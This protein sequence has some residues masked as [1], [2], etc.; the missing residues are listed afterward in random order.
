MSTRPATRGDVAKGWVRY[1][2][3][4]AFPILLLLPSVAIA[5][6]PAPTPP[7]VVRVCA[8]C[9]PAL[10]GGGWQDISDADPRSERAWRSLLFRMQ[11]DYGAEIDPDE[12][13]DLVE[14]LER[15]TR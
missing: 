4:R 14:F 6:E 3:Y 15:M 13:P 7:A 8:E 9:H 12:K 10:P 1:L 2:A 11:E 5:G